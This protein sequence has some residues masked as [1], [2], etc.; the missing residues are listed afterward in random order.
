[1]VG[2]RGH[3][4][5]FTNPDPKIHNYFL[6]SK[7]DVHEEAQNIE[8][9]KFDKLKEKEKIYRSLINNVCIYCHDQKIIVGLT[10]ED[11]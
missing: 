9:G 10:K 7:V 2:I 11:G 4:L 1:M 3:L 5:E 8:D 6:R